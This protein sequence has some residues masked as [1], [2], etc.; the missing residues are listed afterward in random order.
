ML[1]I[2]VEKS[3]RHV[4]PQKRILAFREVEPL[5][6]FVLVEMI[7]GRSRTVTVRERT[8]IILPIQY[9]RFRDANL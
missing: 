3:L 4:V 7:R 6:S 8:A 5:E 2:W 1:F 9:G